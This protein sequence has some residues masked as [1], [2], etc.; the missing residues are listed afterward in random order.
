[1]HSLIRLWTKCGSKL[2]SEEQ[3]KL[4]ESH[5]GAFEISYEARLSLLSTPPPE[6][7]EQEF[8]KMSLLPLKRQIPGGESAQETPSSHGI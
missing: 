3:K 4:H 6:I 7:D 5:K 2:K 8:S 1:M